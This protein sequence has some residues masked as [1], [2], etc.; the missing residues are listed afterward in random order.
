[1]PIDMSAATTPAIEVAAWRAH[2]PQA[3]PAIANISANYRR[4]GC[5][6]QRGHSAEPP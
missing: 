1:M 6:T 5:R 2:L 3:R 4:A